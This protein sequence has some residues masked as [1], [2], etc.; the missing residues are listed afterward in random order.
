MSAAKTANG[1]LDDY[2]SVVDNIFGK[3]AQKQSEY[4]SQEEMDSMMQEVGANILNDDEDVLPSDLLD[5][6]DIGLQV[7]VD[8]P[9][10]SHVADEEDNNEEL[11]PI[12]I[13]VELAIGIET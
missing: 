6:A 1:D 7:T 2:E 8:D 10:V 11:E 4:V 12:G 13:V 9:Q 3:L 5:S